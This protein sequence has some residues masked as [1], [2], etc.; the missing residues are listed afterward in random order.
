M[1][2]ATQK[3][4]FMASEGDEWFNR[5][6][7]ALSR[8]DEDL[9]VEML[10]FNNLA[11]KK[12]LEIGCSNGSRLN[13]MNKVFGSECFGIDPSPKAIEDG[14]RAH[15]QLSL[16]V[17]TADAL[18]FDIDSFDMVVFGFCLYLCDRKDL[19]RIAYE[20]DRCLSNHGTLVIKDFLPSIPFRNRY[21]HHESV[22]SFKMDYS[23]MFTWN[24]AYSEIA[25]VVTSHS[26]FVLRDVPNEKVG[27]VVLRK[28][29]EYAY[30]DEPF[31]KA[32]GSTTLP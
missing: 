14:L 29:E 17:G 20:A 19:F 16:Q 22:Y 21:L 24:P 2:K 18:P 13:R 11:P 27:I 12:I 4:I 26:G 32:A 7:Q 9:V 6:A 15:P 5:N 8:A 30:L 23:M 1:K 10:R 31:T 25:K 28:N 3:S